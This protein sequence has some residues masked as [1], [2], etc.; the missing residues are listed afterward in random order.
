[1]VALSRTETD[2]ALLR[3]AAG[4]SRLGTAAE[5][6]FVHVMPAGVSDGDAARAEEDI[7]KSVGEHFAGPPTKVAPAFDV[8]R[9]PLIDQL[10][11]YT[12][13]RSTDLLLLGHSRDHPA[14][15]ALARRMAMKASCSVWMVPEGSPGT[16]D[17]VLVPVDFSEHSADTLRVATAMLKLA[18][19]GECL[20]LHVYFDYSTA[21][22][23]GHDAAVRAR[24][25][26]ALRK[27]LTSIDGHG[28][29]V[30][31]L[32]EQGVNVADAINQVAERQKC[33]LIV[34]A[35][36]GRSPSAAILL[37]SVTEAAIQKTHVP[38][39]AVKH[40]GTQMG[41]LRALWEKTVRQPDTTQF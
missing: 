26:E 16:T 31:P 13:A 5:V 11:E 38:L 10:L 40:Y 37:G 24:E 28:V 1:M 29:K 2:A 14:R 35:T 12:S 22:Y 34:L 3:Y 27:F 32:V 18:G 7:R 41:F 6:R 4:V 33:D 39:L 20:V 15:G 17:R 21:M 36:R 23:E 25:E 9:G 8:L 30:T 19:R